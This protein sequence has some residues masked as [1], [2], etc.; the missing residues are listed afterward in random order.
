MHP[1]HVPLEG[2]SQATFGDGSRHLGPC[3]GLLGYGEAARMFLRDGTVQ[4]LDEF[5]R[6][7]IFPATEAVWNPF[8]ALAAI[9]ENQRSPLGVLPPTRVLVLVQRR[10]I[11]APQRKIVLGEMGR[12]PVQNDTKPGTVAVID[13]VAEIIR[14]AITCCGRK[15]GAHLI[16]PRTGKWVLGQGEK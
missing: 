3:G 1:A 8:S 15:I 16:S 12:Y 2:E 6:L 7:Q 13:Q 11:E 4:L 5:N 14:R 9:V 10:S